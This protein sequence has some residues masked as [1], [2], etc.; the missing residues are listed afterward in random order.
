M[1]VQQFFVKGLA[2][3]SYILAGK[4]SCAIIDPKRDVD[5]LA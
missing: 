2:H 5:I 1:Y 3:L 4:Q